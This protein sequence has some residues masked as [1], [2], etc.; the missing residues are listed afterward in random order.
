[1]SRFFATYTYT[2][3]QWKWQKLQLSSTGS[4][5]SKLCRLVSKLCGPSKSASLYSLL[6]WKYR[7]FLHIVYWQWEPTQ[8]WPW[9]KAILDDCVLLVISC[10]ICLSWRSSLLLSKI[11]CLTK[12][13]SQLVIPNFLPNLSSV[14]CI[15]EKVCWFNNLPI[16]GVTKFHRYQTKLQKN[17]CF[18]WICE[19]SDCRKC[20]MLPKIRKSVSPANNYHSS[21][22][23]FII[24][25]RSQRIA[26][27]KT[28]QNEMVTLSS[29]V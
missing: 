17:F 20:K 11:F 1:M 15:G 9:D 21:C 2:Y 27:T 22:V 8:N 5:A 29:S 6:M 24:C 7:I 16:L 19:A 26:T 3:T 10:N 4:E 25:S 14:H 13:T 23:L 18:T 12:D 28:K